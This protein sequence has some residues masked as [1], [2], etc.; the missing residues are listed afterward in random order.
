MS[1]YYAKRSGKKRK[2]WIKMTV[3]VNVESQM[4]LAEDVRRGLGNDG[5]I[6]REMVEE[7][8]IPVFY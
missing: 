8:D 2:S 1:Y 3:V 5:I 7:G 6:L 4:I